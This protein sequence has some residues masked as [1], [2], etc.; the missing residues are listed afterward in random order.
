MVRCSGIDRKA[1]PD[2]GHARDLLSQRLRQAQGLVLVLRLV[3]AEA[4]NE[5]VPE[6][7]VAITTATYPLLRLFCPRSF[8]EGMLPA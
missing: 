7:V 8:R 5:L 6:V 2:L 1:C 3:I 4:E